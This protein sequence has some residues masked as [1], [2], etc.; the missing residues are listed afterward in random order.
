MCLAR[1][2]V[3]TTACL[4]GDQF[5]NADQI[6]GDQV[7]YE[8]GGNTTDAAMLCFAHRAMLLTPAEHAFDHR[9][10]RLRH[11]ISLVARGPLVDGASTVPAGFGDAVV[12]RHV[13]RDVDGA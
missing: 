9:P 4:S 7:K 2:L 1:S 8:V 3:R 11:A 13:R 5:G 12:L 6:V 10:A